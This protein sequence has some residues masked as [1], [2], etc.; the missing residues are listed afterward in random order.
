MENFACEVSTGF[1][2]QLLSTENGTYQKNTP[3][4]PR[5]SDT[6]V[7]LTGTPVCRVFSWPFT[8]GGDLS[9]PM[10]RGQVQGDKAL[11]GGL[12]RG[13][14]HVDLMGGT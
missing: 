12:M 13:D 7:V 9:P 11:M 3:K 14:I 5:L 8:H 2:I 4:D 1:K 10:W 6:T